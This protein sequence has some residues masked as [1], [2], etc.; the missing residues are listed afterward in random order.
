MPSWRLLEVYSGCLRQGQGKLRSQQQ[1]QCRVLAQLC[2]QSQLMILWRRQGQPVLLLQVTSL[3]RRQR[4]FQVQKR[5]AWHKRSLTASL[6]QGPRCASLAICWIVHYGWPQV[7]S[8]CITSLKLH[9]R[10][11]QSG[12]LRMRLMEAQVSLLHC[13]FRS[14]LR[15]CKALHR[16]GRCSTSCMRWRHGVARCLGTSASSSDQLGRPDKI[17]QPQRLAITMMLHRVDRGVKQNARRRSLER[18]RKFQITRTAKMLRPERRG[19]C[20]TLRCQL[21]LRR[22]SW[23]LR[24]HTT[25]LLRR[26]NQVSRHGRLR[27]RRHRR[28]RFCLLSPATAALALLRLRI[29][30]GSGR[31]LQRLQQLSLSRGSHV[32]M[33]AASPILSRRLNPSQRLPE[34]HSYCLHRRKAVLRVGQVYGSGA[35]RLF[36]ASH[37]S[38]VLLHKTL[39]ARLPCRAPPPASGCCSTLSHTV[40]EGSR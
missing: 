30:E 31:G 33:R 13:P 22:R 27:L 39:A 4:S 38:Q 23:H 40:E 10:Q 8:S 19:R 20:R 25:T 18:P 9:G 28:I 1:L 26:H 35:V 11:L 34:G 32:Q 21:Q 12:A 7:L 14:R 16:P 24:R 29:R 37:S 5:F 17:W 2:W 36:D 3:H 15:P 6:S